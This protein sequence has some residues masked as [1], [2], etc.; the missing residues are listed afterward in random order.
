MDS[1]LHTQVYEYDRKLMRLKTMANLSPRSRQQYEEEEAVGCLSHDA[2]AVWHATHLLEKGDVSIRRLGTAQGR[3]DVQT[4]LTGK[5]ALRKPGEQFDEASRGVD[6]GRERVR[7][8][9]IS[10]TPKGDNTL[11]A[12][13]SMGHKRPATISAGARRR[14]SFVPCS[15]SIPSSPLPI[16]AR[17]TGATGADVT[18][19]LGHA[20]QLAARSRSLSPGD[21]MSSSLSL[22]DRAR[23]VLGLA[24][25]AS[26]HVPDCT[27]THTAARCDSASGVA[28]AR[29]LPAMQKATAGGRSAEPLGHGGC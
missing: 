14:V 25:L 13:M 4:A 22:G 23:A 18:A 6:R 5:S 11:R 24:R 8:G 27:H 7:Q 19:E 28:N 2:A 20:A 1:V 16:R 15:R 9:S 17:S 21:K 10:G 12:A 3:R 26:G 29:A